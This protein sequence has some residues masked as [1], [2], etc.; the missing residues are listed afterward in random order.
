MWYDMKKELGNGHC[1]FLI[2]E[3]E[4]QEEFEDSGE[5]FKTDSDEFARRMAPYAETALMIFE[6]INLEATYTNDKVKLSEKRSM[7][8]DKAVV[9]SYGNH[10]I[11]K[12]EN[13]WAKS[14]QD[15][16]DDSDWDDVPFIW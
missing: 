8:K 10:I 4:F 13:Q 3:R 6:A 14:N 2:D 11:S 7:T 16:P 9:M 12:L 15:E 1:K 5:Y